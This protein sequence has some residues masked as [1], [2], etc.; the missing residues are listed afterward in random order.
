MS[1]RVV[2]KKKLAQA[3]MEA[4]VETMGA[5]GLFGGIDESLGVNNTFRAGDPN[6]TRQDLLPQI[7]QA[8]QSQADVY[9]QQ[10]ALA[11]ALLAQSQGQGPDPAQAMLN[12]ATGQNVSNQ[13]ALMA[14]ARGANA[15]PA[16]IAKLAAQQ[17][18]AAQQASIGQGAGLQA[19]YQIAVQDALAKQQ[20]AMANQALQQESL[21]QGALAAENTALTAGSLGAQQINANVAGQNATTRGTVAG[22]ILSGIASVGSMLASGMGGMYEGG[23][24]PH[25]ADGGLM[26]IANYATPGVMAVP[27]W[28][29]PMQENAA[30]KAGVADIM[31][32]KRPGAGQPT[33]LGGPQAGGAADSFEM[34]KGKGTDPGMAPSSIGPGAIDSF[35]GVGQGMMFAS[36]GGQAPVV[37]DARAG[38]KVPGRA[39]V[40]GDHIKNDTQPAVLSPG[41]IVI[42]RS[43]AQHENAPE[44]AAKFVEELKKNGSKKPP[45]FEEVVKSKKDLKSRVEALEKMACGGMVKRYADGGDVELEAGTPV[46]VTPVP[47]MPM[48][49]TP[50]NPVGVIQTPVPVAVP[51][52]APMTPMI[53][54]QSTM[55][56]MGDDDQ[57]PEPT[58]ESSPMAA[59]GSE[60][61]GQE[62]PVPVAP[63]PTQ[64]DLSQF[65]K[66]VNLEAAGTY[67]AANAKAKELDE[68]ALAHKNSNKAIKEVMDT[69]N[70]KIANLDKENK[71]LSDDIASQK[72]DPTR[73]YQNMSTGQKI[74]RS[75]ALVL[76]GLGASLT[77][78]PNI[79]YEMIEKEVE[80]DI[81]AQKANIGKKQNLLSANMQKY[82]NINAA[83]QATMMQI[84][85]AIQ[86]QIA[87][88]AAK[89]GGA[90][91]NA[92]AQALVAKLKNENLVRGQE[93]K[94]TVFR[95][96]M[97]SKLMKGGT[98]GA[99]DPA[100]FVKFLVPPEH[101]KKVFDEIETAKNA[102]RNRGAILEA[103]DNASKEERLMSAESL[104]QKGQALKNL[105]PGQ[106]SPS[107]GA[108]RQGILPLFA[109]IEG[110]VREA[111][112]ENT[113]HNIAPR[114]GDD[115]KTIEIKRN[116]LIRWL[117]SK[118]EGETAKGFGLDLKKFNSTSRLPQLDPNQ[119]K[120]LEWANKNPNDPRAKIVK[121]KLGVVE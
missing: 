84:N 7:S 42:P 75:I 59:E 66:N 5:G 44:L 76:G 93:L 94:A 101:Q 36:H 40:Q 13:A 38:A 24:V 73:F 98:E 107:V 1:D 9:G 46:T 68:V 74:F 8:R 32:P 70:T 80:R 64:S 72:I 92:N 89:Y 4:G 51:V 21:R 10:Q 111:A 53:P 30:L 110:T 57:G 78:G 81:E 6:I 25:M 58:Q 15:N 37:M 79:A 86:G 118:E 112:I 87:Q 99:M 106:S 18:A 17:G 71:A 49:P 43:I 22:G 114:P 117:N 39:Q 105:L 19:Q 16:L 121:K 52:S 96:E 119:Q 82:G 60:D 83:Q 90:F 62:Q 20:Q 109:D 12:Q 3:L 95:H 65:Q 85:A 48:A 116:A 31:N 55:K 91:A 97:M 67:G 14:G 54:V 35:E 2:M 23:E 115:D 120:Y 88:A 47:T 113:F 56:G 108:L 77:K 103:F 50:S 104:Q 61:G 29:N 69:Y 33:A 34:F 45:T 28:V 27:T 26:G 100:P 41:E 63:G 102:T 11:N